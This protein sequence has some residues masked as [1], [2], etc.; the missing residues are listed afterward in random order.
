MWNHTG[1]DKA[2]VWVFYT[3]VVFRIFL[4]CERVK[5]DD[6]E[7]LQQTGEVRRQH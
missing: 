7:A 1:E 5:R 2:N 6:E 4:Q 3:F